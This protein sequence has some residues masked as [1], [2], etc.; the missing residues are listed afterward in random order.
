MIAFSPRGQ[1]AAGRGRPQQDAEQGQQSSGSSGSGESFPSAQHEAGQEQQGQSRSMPMHLHVSPAP[2]LTQRRRGRPQRSTAQP[3]ASRSQE[4]VSGRQHLQPQDVQMRTAGG[5]LVPSDH[6]ELRQP[7]AQQQQ[8]QRGGAHGSRLE[9]AQAQLLQTPPSHQPGLVR[10]DNGASASQQRQVE[11]LT[12]QVRLLEVEAATARAAMGQAVEAAVA[13]EQRRRST[14][15]QLAASD[16]SELV[17]NLSCTALQCN[18]FRAYRQSWNVWEPSTGH[19][20]AN[21][22]AKCCALYCLLS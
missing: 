20:L 7:E 12:A 4:S 10:Q 19:G 2:A 5:A 16:V 18:A 8:L 22:D 21:R 11:A 15:D 3:L 13:Q 17:C 1:R 14:S 6:Q 9:Q